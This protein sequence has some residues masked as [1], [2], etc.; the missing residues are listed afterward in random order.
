M[1]FEDAL[2]IFDTIQ[3]DFLFMGDYII[4]KN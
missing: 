4:E 1:S 2:R 3:A